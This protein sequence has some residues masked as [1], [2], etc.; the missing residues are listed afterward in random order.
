MLRLIRQNPDCIPVDPG[1]IGDIINLCA[2]RN[3]GVLTTLLSLLIGL[4]K[5]DPDSYEPAVERVIDIL[6][7]VN[8]VFLIRQQL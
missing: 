6:E 7:R 5:L 1:V 8:F 2:D 3:E 4:S